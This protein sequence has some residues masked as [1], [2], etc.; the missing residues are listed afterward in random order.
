MSAIKVEVH[1]E[2]E[3]IKELFENAEVKFSKKKLAEL[4]S[5]VDHADL[6]IKERLEE[7]LAEII[8]EMI[9]DEWGE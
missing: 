8:E 3:Q 9:A 5:N 4:K 1:L 2:Q 6:E 7:L